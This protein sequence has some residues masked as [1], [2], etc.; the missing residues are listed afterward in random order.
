[1]SSTTSIDTNVLLLL[2]TQD[3]TWNLRASAAIQEASKRGRLCICGP[4]F[5]ELMGLPGRDAKQLELLIEASGFH[6]E[7]DMNEV[8]WQTAGLAYQGYVRRRKKSGGG[9]PRR[10]LT[11]LLIG[12]HASAR[13]YSLLTMDQ[14]IYSPAFPGLH[15]ESL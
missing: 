6:I 4:V 8:I 14:D 15:I 10:I 3:P 11:D 9:L 5:S 2:W 12:A 1:M 13:G 7:W